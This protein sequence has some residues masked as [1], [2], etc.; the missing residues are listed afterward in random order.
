M[1]DS[2]SSGASVCLSFDLDAISFWVGMLGLSSPTYISRGEFAATVAAPRILDLLDREEVKS[3]WFIPGMD[4][5]AYP[6]V[7]KRIRDSGHEIGHHGYAH[8][9]PT[10]L[11]EPAERRMIE[12]GLEALDQVLGVTPTGYRS[13]AADLSPNTTSLLVEYGFRYDSSLWGSDYGMYRCRT[14]DVVDPELPV[15]FGDELDLVEV[16]L[17]TIIDFVLLEFVMTPGLLLPASTDVVALG[18]R[19]IDDLEFLVDQVPGGTLTGVWHPAAIGRASKL[20][21]VENFIR[22]GKELGVPF[23]TMSEAAEEWKSAH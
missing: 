2:Q 23:K 15:Q 19:W 5:E 3:T 4:A 16:P 21:T 6:D 14:A 18:K 17:G 20:R 7:C 10:N 11:D 8:E 9:V 1:S 13:P 12:R 22:R